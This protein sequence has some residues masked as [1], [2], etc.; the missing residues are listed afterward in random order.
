MLWFWW[1]LC[2]DPF[3]WVKQ[4]N[5]LVCIL[6]PQ[7]A[8]LCSINVVVLLSN[9]GRSSICVCITILYNYVVQVELYWAHKAWLWEDKE[10]EESVRIWSFHCNFPRQA[11]T[12]SL[13]KHIK[14]S[15]PRVCEFI[16]IFAPFL[17]SL[18]IYHVWTCIALWTWGKKWADG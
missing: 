7:S 8:V 18:S 10:W 17:Y 3:H 9:M 15:I 13:I 4:W 16:H 11:I 2:C 1:Q 14:T 12:E 6:C 5:L